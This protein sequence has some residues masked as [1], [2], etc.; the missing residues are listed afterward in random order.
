M[1][2]FLIDGLYTRG[3][4]TH[5]D[6]MST[7]NA[8]RQYGWGVP[9]FVLSQLFNRVFF[10][11]QDTKTPMRFTLIAAAVNIGAGVTLFQLVGVPG[12]AAATSL[13]AWVNVVMMVMTLHRRG[14]Y[15]PSAKTVS[16]LI[17]VT[18]ASTVLGGLLALASH[19][20][21]LLEAP[22][23]GLR[24]GPLG[25]KE[26][27]IVAVSG[28]AVAAFPFLLFAS[29]GLTLTEIRGALRRRPGEKTVPGAQDLG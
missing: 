17:R 18:I 6:A 13:A 8:L 29:G 21:A 12:I 7:A 22:L 2:F 19:E 23:H 27:V 3:A 16:R 14:L 25:P 4:F 15:E 11:S 26:I 10:A 5:F 24:L 1:P 20:R 9:A 28:L